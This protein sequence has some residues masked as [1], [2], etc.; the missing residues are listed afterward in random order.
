M[1]VVICDDEGALAGAVEA[2]AG[3]WSAARGTPCRVRTFASGE[4][5]LF[6]TAGS[7]PYDLILLDIDLGGGNLSGLELARRIRETDARVALAFLTNHPGYV[8]AGYEVSA[9]RY[10]MKPV[11]EDNLFPLLDLVLS[12]LGRASRY[13]AVEADGEHLRLE[14]DAI[15]YLEARG[16]A[17]RIETE[18]G[19]V[20]VKEPLSALAC[21]LGTDFVPAHRS[22]LVNLR[23]VERVGRTACLLEG[24]RSVPVSRGAWE[25][26]SRAFIDYYREA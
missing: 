18:G 17:V 15:L 12:R 16:H 10:L 26:L 22:F 1:R 3:R 7:Y 9:L 11:A 21:R 20:T 24:G 14:E 19:P 25:R 23:R 4:E 8:F 5:L 2:L 13:L 6:E